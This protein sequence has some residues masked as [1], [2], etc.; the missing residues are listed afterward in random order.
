[1]EDI[2]LHLH[3]IVSPYKLEGDR[4]RAELNLKNRLLPVHARLASKRSKLGVQI[5][6]AGTG[7]VEIGTSNKSR[8]N[9]YGHKNTSN[10]KSCHVDPRLDGVDNGI[11]SETDRIR[12]Y[13]T[14]VHQRTEFK[15][16]KA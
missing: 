16:F 10:P 4:A 11:V 2:M 9:P 13:N 1:M 14:R 12:V 3:H 5:M 6:G 7:W 8:Y 15:Q